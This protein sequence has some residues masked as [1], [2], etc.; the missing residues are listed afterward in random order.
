MRN[1]E[2]IIGSQQGISCT[3]SIAANNSKNKQKESNKYEIYL[4]N[5]I[6]GTSIGTVKH[7][8]NLMNINFTELNQLNNRH[9][10]FQS[11]Y[12][13]VPKNK[14]EVVFDPR[15]WQKGLVVREFV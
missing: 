10:Y 7:M 5:V 2:L 1:D 8:L 3:H 4:G 9:G 12:F 6:H 15:N 11:Y 13:K 14:L